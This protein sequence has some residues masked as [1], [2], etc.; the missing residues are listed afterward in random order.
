MRLKEEFNRIIVQETPGCLWLFGMFFAL[1]G[2]V[3]IYGSL[4][5]FVNFGFI[6]LW[7]LLLALIMGAIAVAAGISVIYQAP[8]T[9]VVVDRQAE[10]VTHQRRGIFG[11]KTETYPFDVLRQFTLIEEN[12]G[13]GALMWSLGI[14]LNDGEII[15]VSTLPS[16]TENYKRD[17]VFQINRFI[18]R[19]LLS[20]IT[21][22]QPEDESESKMS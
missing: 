17:F 3:F 21:V 19:P 13:E 12:D 16:H 18:G 14:E 4:G 8:A 7:Q 1:I 9:R 2:G 22:E 20:Y 11:N 15:K 6:P 5:G 10:I